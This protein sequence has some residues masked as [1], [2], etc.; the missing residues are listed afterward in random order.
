MGLYNYLQVP[1]Y[2]PISKTLPLNTIQDNN[3][4]FQQ[5][6]HLAGG[7]R[8]HAGRPTGTQCSQQHCPESTVVSLSKPV[9]HHRVSRQ[10]S[11]EV[12]CRCQQVSS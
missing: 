2:L 4:E 11:K 9:F 6:Y 3:I 5:F 10:F 1:S 7:S 8:K 12:Q